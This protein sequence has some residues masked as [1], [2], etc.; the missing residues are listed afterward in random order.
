MLF[1]YPVI[2][3][4]DIFSESFR[5]FLQLAKRQLLTVFQ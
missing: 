2:N 4:S 5:T 3:V 1:Y